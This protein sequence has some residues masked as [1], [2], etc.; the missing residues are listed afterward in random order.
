MSGNEHSSNRIIQVD[1]ISGVTDSINGDCTLIQVNQYTMTLSSDSDGLDTDP[2][3][4]V[5]GVSDATPETI[6]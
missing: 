4:E 5:Q 3:Q 6:D 2:G 1:T